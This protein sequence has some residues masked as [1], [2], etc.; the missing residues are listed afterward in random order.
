MEV[1]ALCI[2]L[3]MNVLMLLVAQVAFSYSQKAAFPQVVPNRQQHFQYET[4]VVSCEGLEGRTGWRVMREIKGVVK[5]CAATWSTSTGPCEIND[6][7]TAV[8]S[9]EYW[10]EIGGLQTSNTVNITVTA[11]SVVLESPVLPVM[12]GD[13]VTLSCRDKQASPNLTADFY[14]DGHFMESSS[15]GEM[16]IHSVSRSNEGLYKCDI[17]GAGESPESWLT[18]RDADGPQLLLLLCIVVGV[19]LVFLLLLLVGSMRCRRRPTI[20]RDTPTSP[21]TLRSSSSPRTVCE[22]TSMTYSV[23]TK[24]QRK[25]EPGVSVC[26]ETPVLFAGSNH[27]FTEEN[28]CYCMI[29]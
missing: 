4:I 26:S 22:E 7:L 1:T 6:A 8:D 12:E 29:E 5:T 10:C 15:T 19:F 20:T 18:V 2:R 13:V 14:K 16:T 23:I 11:G 27:L 25:E 28:P 3:L 9:G 21:S 17:S 24:P